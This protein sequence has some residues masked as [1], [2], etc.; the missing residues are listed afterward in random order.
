MIQEKLF[1]KK[2]GRK[3]KNKEKITKKLNQNTKVSKLNHRENNQQLIM[4]L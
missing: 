1:N 3:N 2:K 4:N